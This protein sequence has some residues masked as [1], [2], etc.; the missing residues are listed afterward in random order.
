MDFG[1]VLNHPKVGSPIA[2][3]F[4]RYKPGDLLPRSFSDEEMLTQ[5]TDIG[6]P[7]DFLTETPGQLAQ[8]HPHLLQGPTVRQ[9]TD[10]TAIVPST[11][12]FDSTTADPALVQA[13]IQALQTHGSRQ[14]SSDQTKSTYC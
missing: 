10:S 14:A 4:N 6:C 3:K 8:K 1:E 13:L 2:L 9:I 11:S 5:F 12:S 7:P